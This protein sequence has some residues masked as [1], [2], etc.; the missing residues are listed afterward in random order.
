MDNK[1]K[2][3]IRDYS[4]MIIGSVLISIASKNIYDPAG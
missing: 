2:R 1:K 3:L 4:Y